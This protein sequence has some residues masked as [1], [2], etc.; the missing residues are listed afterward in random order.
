MATSDSFGLPKLCAAVMTFAAD[1]SKPF[2]A[3]K[4]LL[5]FDALSHDEI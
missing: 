5:G 1:G 2:R 4:L 3:M